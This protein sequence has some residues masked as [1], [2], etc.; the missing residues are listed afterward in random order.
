MQR[1]V[2]SMALAATGIIAARAIMTLAAKPAVAVPIVAAPAGPLT[3]DQLTII[4]DKME[5]A[6][7]TDHDIC[8]RFAV[9][10]LEKI[11]TAQYEA[12]LAFLA[13]PMGG[14]A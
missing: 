6:A 14:A 4:A 13:N 8:K 2:H 12:V 3:K 7:M 5:D 1:N 11:P 10:A 9:D